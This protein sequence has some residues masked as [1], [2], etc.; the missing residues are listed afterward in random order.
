MSSFILKYKYVG[1][2][3]VMR[4]RTDTKLF[5]A[6]CQEVHNLIS[7]TPI[8]SYPVC[9]R[10]WPS[11]RVISGNGRSQPTATSRVRPVSICY[12][13]GCQGVSPASSVL[14]VSSSFTAC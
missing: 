12:L 4:H 14:F 9:N 6:N 11:A 1:V 7:E 8:F 2:S 3:Q 13:V 5:Y 10:K